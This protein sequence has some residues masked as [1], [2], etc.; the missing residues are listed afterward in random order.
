MGI[1]NSGSESAGCDIVEGQ[2]MR[3]RRAMTSQAL[4]QVVTFPFTPTTR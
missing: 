4:I 3:D 1:M 2:T